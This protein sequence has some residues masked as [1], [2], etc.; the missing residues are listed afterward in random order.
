M[1]VWAILALKSS[2]I[3]LAPTPL[4]KKSKDFPSLRSVSPRLSDARLED[5]RKVMKTLELLVA[6]DNEV[7]SFEYCLSR[8]VRQYLAEATSPSTKQMH[9][10]RKLADCINEVSMVV[11][12]VA[13]NGQTA[14]G[15]SR[16]PKRTK[17]VPC[18]DGRTLDVNHTN[19]SF[20]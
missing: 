18:R 15:C 12:I 1:S 4:L 17:G 6:I 19:L 13:S 14:S 20:S 8:L 5:I 16:H 2:T 7:D 3:W 10:K 11:S 9:G